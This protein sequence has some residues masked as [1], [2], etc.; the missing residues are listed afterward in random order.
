MW[1]GRRRVLVLVEL[2]EFYIG[3]FAGDDLLLQI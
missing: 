2:N 3:Q 1:E